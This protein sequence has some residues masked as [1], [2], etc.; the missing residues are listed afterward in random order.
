MGGKAPYKEFLQKGLMKKPQRYQ[1]GTGAL[2]K[3]SQYQASTE[4]FICKHPS[5]YLMCKIAKDCGKY[6]LYF[7]VFMVMALQEA[8]EYYLTS[9][10]EDMNLCAIHLK[11][12][13]IMP[14]DIQLACCI[15]GEHLH[16]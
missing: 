7:Q 4:V 11:H 13:T 5:T 14:K 3:I 6:D 12:V 15:H 8:A 10:L 1:P 9:L 16:Y 2:H